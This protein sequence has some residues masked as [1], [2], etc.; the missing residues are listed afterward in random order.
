MCNENFEFY[1]VLEYRTKLLW[2]YKTHDQLN[3]NVTT[4]NFI[5][6]SGFVHLQD[7]CMKKPG[8]DEMEDSFANS[9]T[10]RGLRSFG[11]LRGVAG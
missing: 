11:M 7:R 1:N 10:S 4:K 6:W 3:I 9:N 8:A 5:K 2:L